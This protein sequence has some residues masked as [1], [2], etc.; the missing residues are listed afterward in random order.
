M[1]RDSNRSRYSNNNI[2]RNQRRG[3]AGYNNS[4][5]SS[6]DGGRQYRRP[7]E[8]SG[9]TSQRSTQSRMNNAPRAAARPTWQSDRSINWLVDSG[10]GNSNR[11]KWIIAGVSVLVVLLI[12]VG[13]VLG[14]A[15]CILGKID[16]MS[17]EELAIPDNL[18]SI[19]LEDD[20]VT[21]ASDT[22]D[23][24]QKE[25]IDTGIKE[26]V[27]GDD[28]LRYED[29]VTNI[30][31]L[32]MDARRVTSNR[33]RSDVIIIVSINENSKKIV[34]S[35]IMRDT[36]VSIPG[37]SGNDKINAASAYGGPALTVDTVEGAFGIKIDHFVVVNFYS[38]MD[39]VD[40]LG[41][42]TVEINSGEKKV[43][44]TYI[45]EINRVNGL[46]LGD[47]KLN[48]TGDAVH[49]TGK[50]AMGYVRIRYSGNG[51]YERTERQREVLE[52]LIQK[53]RQADYSTLISLVDDVASN[54][55]TDYSMSEI[56][57]LAMNATKYIDYDISQI[58]IPADGTFWSGIYKGVWILDIN[59]E[60]NREMLYKA[61]FD[62]Y[63]NE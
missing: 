39:I 7:A 4:G 1:D 14:Y 41:G 45:E 38:F 33:S 25:Q 60:E 46:P 3:S 29:G 19:V 63:G 26:S 50:Q 17:D 15:S 62:N 16:Y 5:Y 37:R 52:Q 42:V 18:D 51:D 40:A 22:I 53:A 31:V 59:F 57:S 55:S 10:N 56:T 49:L 34:L 54:V 11:K 27:V 6:N 2:D 30:L 61:I 9:M 48:T 47:G 58:R 32:G 35:S 44:N 36:Y 12:I 43:L 28:G 23:D 21:S 13:I 24:T 20:D 8:R